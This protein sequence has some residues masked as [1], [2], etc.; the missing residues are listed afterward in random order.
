MNA[1][2]KAAEKTTKKIT[3]KTIDINCDMGESFGAYTIGMD[4]EVIAHITSANIACGFHAGDPLVLSRT[5]RL[6]AENGVGVGAHPG[7]PDLMGFGRRKMECSPEEIRNYVIYQVGAV[8][9][10][11]KAHG[12]VLQHVKPHGGLYNMAAEDETIVETIAGAIADIDHN[13]IMVCLAGKNAPRFREIAK[14]AGI[15]VV[16]EAFP[17][18]AYTGEGVLAPRSSLGAVIKDPETVARRAVMMAAE[19]MIEAADGSML[20]L[21]PD[22][23]CVHGDTPAAVDLAR[24]IREALQKN[25]LNVIPMAQILSLGQGRTPS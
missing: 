16:F 15:R 4:R 2:G 7:F 3:E 21:E 8:L 1:T 22:T 9:G 5:V 20:T 24:S 17:D 19:G 10:F 14:K 23:L 6:A 11:C 25:G 18:R 13:L 12:A